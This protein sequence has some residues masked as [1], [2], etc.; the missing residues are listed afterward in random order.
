M[1]GIF[2][3]GM[4][5]IWSQKAYVKVFYCVYINFKA[6][7]NIFEYMEIAQYV[8]E[9]VIEPSYENLL[10]NIPTVLVKEGK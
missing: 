5:N 2:L 7:I 9:G 1:N 8:Y 3:I 10:G 6:A 4:P